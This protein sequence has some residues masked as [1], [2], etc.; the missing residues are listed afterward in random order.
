MQVRAAYAAATF[1]G[2]VPASNPVADIA[3]AAACVADAL[4]GQACLDGVDQDAWEGTC[5]GDVVAAGT[6]FAEAYRS[7]LVLGGEV[8]RVL[9]HQQTERD[10]ESDVGSDELLAVGCAAWWPT[11]EG[12]SWV[13]DRCVSSENDRG[14]MAC[15]PETCHEAGN[16]LVDQFLVE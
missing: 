14:W 15:R 1:A 13:V 11:V 6:T 12:S 8:V 9:L 10:Q 7:F 5:V 4:V 3:V 2:T 16:Y